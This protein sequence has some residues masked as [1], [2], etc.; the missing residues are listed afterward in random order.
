MISK[1][2]VQE[3][4]E[5][6]RRWVRELPDESREAFYKETEKALKDP[7]TYATLNY[8]FIAGLHHFY[9]GKW[10]LG[11][12][13]TAIFWSGVALVFTRHFMLGIATITAITLF[14]FYELF[15]S[16]TLVQHHNNDVMER[17]YHDNY[18]AES[19]R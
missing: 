7:D 10:R 9:L 8:I 17:I 1:E 15:R 6:I 12:I 18:T 2:A 4:E 5:S 14:E 13:N 3:R 11:L 16:Q 19:R